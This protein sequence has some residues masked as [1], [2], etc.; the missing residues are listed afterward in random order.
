MSR[1]KTDWETLR[2]VAEHS[3]PEYADQIRRRNQRLLDALEE[4]VNS[5]DTERLIRSVTIGC[6]HCDGYCGDCL[7]SIASNGPAQ[8]CTTVAFNGVRLRDMNVSQGYRTV[9][10]SYSAGS[11][12]ITRSPNE[13]HK[14]DVNDCR[15]FLRGHIEWANRKYWGRKYEK[16][17]K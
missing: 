12:W 15:R 11:A 8:P 7:W 14:P 6:P 3:P 17:A 1:Y 9:V 2:Y 16:E 5:G 4:M 13:I 10:V